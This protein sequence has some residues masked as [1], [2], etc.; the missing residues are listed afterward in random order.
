MTYVRIYDDDSGESHFEDVT[1]P[2]TAANFAP[3]APPIQ[4]APAIK[5]ERL[6]LATAQAGWY[7]EWHPSPARQFFIQLSGDLEIETSDGE[8]RTFGAGEIIL[9]EDTH[10]KGHRSRVVGEEPL[11]MVFVQLKEDRR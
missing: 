7:G 8:K 6:I 2:L 9:L 3:P 4:T 10:G 5:T 11:A 1:T